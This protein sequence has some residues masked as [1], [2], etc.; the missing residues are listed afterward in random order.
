MGEKKSLHDRL[1]DNNLTFV[2]LISF[3]DRVGV[4][5]DKSEM[6]SAVRGT[7]SGDKAANIIE[8]SHQIL[9]KYEDFIRSVEV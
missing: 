2:W 8:K 5:T 9:D 7:I 3:L 6:S 4:H 1:R